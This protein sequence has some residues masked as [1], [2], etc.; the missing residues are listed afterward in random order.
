M[1]LLKTIILLTATLT[2]AVACHNRGNTDAG[3][4]E[5]SHSATQAVDMSN[6]T[7]YVISD[8]NADERVVDT[9]SF[10][11]MFSGEQA[12]QRIAL[13]N[14]TSKPMVIIRTETSCGCTVAE[15]D[16]APVQKGDTL[17]MTFGFDSRGFHGWQLKRMAIHTSASPKP[18]IIYLEAEVE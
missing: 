3:S 10:G 17:L 18:V 11:R 7:T 9:L 14:S 8:A 15:Y 5:T 13:V 12:R 1:R 2:A 6:V 4:D 16:K